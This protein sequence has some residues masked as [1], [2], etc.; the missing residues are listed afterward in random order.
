MAGPLRFRVPLPVLIATALAMVGAL[1]LIYVV[2][3]ETGGHREL[4]SQRQEDRA[5]ANLVAAE[6]GRGAAVQALSGINGLLADE[7]MRAVVDLPTGT[8][9][10]G[11][12]PAP[13]SQLA[14]A[15]V[16]IKGGGSVTVV[17]EADATPDPPLLVVLLTTGALVLVLGVAV[18]ANV[19]TTHQ[20]RHKVSLAVAAAERIADGDF[21]ARIGTDGPGALGA[22]GAA[23]DSMAAR[24]EEGDAT[25]RELLADLAHEIATPIHAVTGYAQAVLDGTIPAERAKGAIEGQTARLSGLLD[26]LAQ[27]RA[28]DAPPQGTSERTDLRSL[29]GDVLAELAPMAGHVRLRRRL[30]PALVVTDPQLVRTVVSNLLTNAFRFTPEGGTVE[31]HTGRS[32]HRAWVAVRDGGPGISHEDQHRVFDRFYRVESSRDRA[33]GG[34]GLGLAIAQRAARGI[35]GRI[36]LRSEVGRGSEFRLVLAHDRWPA[37]RAAGPAGDPADQPVAGP[38]GDP[39]GEPSPG[40]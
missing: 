21:G 39:A 27:L 38:A 5:V 10:L 24:L 31:V 22:L 7:H 29:V 6:A 12:E 8:V 37:E 30:S 32:G 3:T 36:E 15:T 34:S 16:P 17:S 20:T 40:T 18:T 23:F 11:H 4:A 33:R 28:L 19:A 26:E 14:S 13:G 25:Q 1:I 2:L 9:V 35:G